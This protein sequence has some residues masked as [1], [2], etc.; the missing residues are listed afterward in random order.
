MSARRQSLP[1]INYAC[2]PMVSPKPR[3][4]GMLLRGPFFKRHAN[5]TGEPSTDEALL[6]K[7]A[8]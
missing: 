4:L 5:S 7:G 6:G 1:L 2:G 8:G 3:V